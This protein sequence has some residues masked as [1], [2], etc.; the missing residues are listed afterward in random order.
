MAFAKENG[1]PIAIK[2]AF[3][4]G[5]RGLKVARELDEVA[6]LYDSAVREAI[7]AFG[8]GECFVE[9]YLDNPATW[10]PSARGLARQRCGRFH[11]RLLA[12][13]SASEAG[14]GSPSTVPHR[15]ARSRVYRASKAIIKAA[16]YV[17]AGT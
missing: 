4:G 13:A 15:G 7:A 5:G 10:K 6:E 9:R 16:G 2:A 1:L 11:P 17:G 8:R 3:G 12:A 14:G